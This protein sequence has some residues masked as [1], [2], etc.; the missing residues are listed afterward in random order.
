[1]KVLSSSDMENTRYAVNGTA[2]SLGNMEA[3]G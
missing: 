1:M 3:E 2:F